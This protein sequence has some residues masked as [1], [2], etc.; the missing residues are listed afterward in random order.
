[1]SQMKFLED[2]SRRL[3]RM[4]VELN[5]QADLLREAL[6]KS[7]TASSATRA[8]LEGGGDE[9]GPHRDGLPG[10]R[11]Q[12]DLFLLQLEA[13]PRERADRRAAGRAGPR[14]QGL[15][16]RLVVPVSG[17]REGARLEPQAGPPDLLRA[18]TEPM[19]QAPA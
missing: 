12:L 16:V 15:G 19:D 3:K 17:Q 6:G 5:M 9:G 8:G 13:R 10:V 2:E 1:M 4:F 18:G 14:L 11:G 7:E